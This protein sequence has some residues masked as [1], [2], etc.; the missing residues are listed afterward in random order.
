MENVNIWLNNPKVKDLLSRGWVWGDVN[1]LLTLFLV[2]EGGVIFSFDPLC[3]SQE[4]DLLW[5]PNC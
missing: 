1:G 4:A 5:E 3:A 2:N